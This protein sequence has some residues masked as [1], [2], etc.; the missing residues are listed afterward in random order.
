[1]YINYDINLKDD[2]RG[3]SIIFSDLTHNQVDDI[4]N[5]L[6]SIVKFAENSSIKEWSKEIDTQKYLNYLAKIVKQ[7][8][9]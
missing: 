5:L 3:S 2:S 1:M 7:S 8:N 9:D 4:R 6:S